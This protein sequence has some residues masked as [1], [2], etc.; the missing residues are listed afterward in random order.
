[1]ATKKGAAEKAPKRSRSKKVSAE[2]SSTAN[3]PN[4]EVIP[5]KP[6]APMPRLS[7]DPSAAAQ[8][9]PSDGG[10][11][12]TL[13]NGLAAALKGHRKMAFQD[14]ERYIH[15]ADPAI[16]VSQAGNTLTLQKGDLKETIEL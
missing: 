16:R 10:A 1:M 8:A 4:L 7:N 3:T 9:V 15:N 12:K 11:F 13:V 5:E 2:K 6:A 14:T